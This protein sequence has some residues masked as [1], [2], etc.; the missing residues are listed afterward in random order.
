MDLDNETCAY[1]IFG[2]IFALQT[3]KKIKSFNPA[4]GQ[5]IVTEIQ[6]HWYIVFIKLNKSIKISKKK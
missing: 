1:N 6:Q 3:T 5:L 2:E 4:S